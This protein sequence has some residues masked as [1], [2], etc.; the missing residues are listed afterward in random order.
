MSCLLAKGVVDMRQEGLAHP[1]AGKVLHFQRNWGA[2]TADQWVLNCVKGYEIAWTTRPTQPIPPRELVFPKQ[3]ADGLSTEVQSLLQ[4]QAVSELQE[5]TGTQCFLSQLF[6][7]PKKDGGVR[8]VVNLKALNSFVESTSFKM[9][10]IH[11]LKDL[12]RPGDWM[13]KIDLKDAY[14]AI[15]VACQHRKYLAFRWQ[16]KTYQFNCLPF[17]LS[18]APW[19][20]TK[21][22]KP[23]V[24]ILRSL[25]LRMIIYIDDILILAADVKTAQEHTECM[26]F[27]L[28]NLGLTVNREKSL[29]NPTQELEYLGLITDSAHMQLRLP[30]SKIKGIR[31]D[32]KAISERSQPSARMVSRLLGKLAQ[33]AH[34]VTAAPLFYRHLQHS[35]RQSLAQSGQDYCQTCQLNDEAREELTW[36]TTNLQTW[37][38][39]SILKPTPDLTIESD[40]S[41]IGWGARC[42]STR[43]GGPWSNNEA[44][45]H[46]NCQELLAAY[47][48]IKSFVKDQSNICVLLRTDNSSALTYINKFGGTV[49]QE[50]NQIA[51]EL[52]T[53]CFQRNITITAA[54]L[55]GVSNVAADHES[56]HMMDR[57]DWRLNPQIFEKI[58]QIF[59]PQEV[60]L[61]ASR[62]TTQLPTYVSWRPDPSAW[63]IDAFT[64][65]WSHFKGYANPPWNLIAKVLNQTRRQ[66]A[67]LVLIAP[68]WRG[69]PWY[70]TLLEMTI[71]K[72]LLIRVSPSVIQPTHPVNR[73]DIQ[74]QLAVWHISGKDSLI[75]DFQK[76]LQG[77]CS[78]LGG[79]SLGSL[80]TH[81][82]PNGPAGVTNGIS[83]PFQEISLE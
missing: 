57:S 50:L 66:A 5:M 76:R 12:L 27:L 73:P 75:K 4:K 16:G 69:Q 31:S 2:I 78:P 7:V 19:V 67:T 72:P 8:P 54:F 52:W 60:D 15:P 70:P 40:A 39:K 74:P 62:L 53:W 34:A 28:E 61:F 11:M 83:I 18:S 77:S 82:L 36:W 26:I 68:V 81:S 56:R 45:M 47:L 43:T 22:T 65:N 44:K 21:T 25:G 17:G 80:T 14:F 51:K 6:A 55:P 29:T 38:G 13:T 46:I 3:E 42:G 49:S 37:N 71:E 32:A 20:F 23:V 63:A 24:T 35:L 58:N 33:A 41:G 48:A 64:L 59:G 30:G 79:K 10:G 9:E 1:N